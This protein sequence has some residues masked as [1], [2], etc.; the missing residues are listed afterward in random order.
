[1]TNIN[2]NITNVQ[3]FNGDGIQVYPLNAIHSVVGLSDKLNEIDSS[4]N[5]IIEIINTSEELPE[6]LIKQLNDISTNILK[7][8]DNISSINSSINEMNESID[9][10]TDDVELLNNNYSNVVKKDE[11][12]E[13][14]NIH[15]KKINNKITKTTNIYT[16][17]ENFDSKMENNNNYRIAFMKRSKK[18]GKGNE[19]RVPLFNKKSIKNN[20]YFIGGKQLDNPLGDWSITGATTLNPDIASLPCTDMKTKKNARQYKYYYYPINE[21]GDLDYIKDTTYIFKNSSSKKIHI[22]YA[23]FKFNESKNRWD[24]VSNI[25]MIDLYAYEISKNNSNQE[26]KK[27]FINII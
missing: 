23:I 17:I 1:M 20:Y 10:V 11:A 21:G 12:I 2:E 4:I 27:Y 5:D 9:V 8:N 25:A 24:R 22:G 18:K 6:H 3:T 15:L 7:I 26:V 19:W 13:M 16:V 14:Y